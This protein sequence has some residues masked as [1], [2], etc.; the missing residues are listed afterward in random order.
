MRLL[1]FPLCFVFMVLWSPINAQSGLRKG[2]GQKPKPTTKPISNVTSPAVQSIGNDD[3]KVLY[4]F[5]HLPT[6]EDHSEEGKRLE[7]F[8]PAALP[9]L[10]LYNY[11]E[12]LPGYIDMTRRISFIMM[13]GLVEEIPQQYEDGDAMLEF[14]SD[15]RQNVTAPADNDVVYLSLNQR[16]YPDQ[17][18]RA[19]Q[20]TMRHTKNNELWIR[21][22]L[23]IG[24]YQD[25]PSGYHY[26]QIISFYPAVYG[27]KAQNE[28]DYYFDNLKINSYE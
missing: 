15:W 28:V 1:L 21:N 23:Q 26:I 4:S 7:S 13:E 9:V 2:Q 3:S 14:Y 19:Y 5:D 27:E 6:F 10:P 25:E 8:L 20:H 17:N 11:S 12:D 24:R 22:E 16:E 18:A